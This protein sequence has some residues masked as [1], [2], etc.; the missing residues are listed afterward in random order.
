MI[1]ID[2]LQEAVR[3]GREAETANQ[4][5][6][7]YIER[8]RQSIFQ[9]WAQEGNQELREAAWHLVRGFDLVKKR[10]ADDI[11][12]GTQ[13]AQELAYRDRENTK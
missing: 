8:T 10:I 6:A 13:A 9:A 11:A 5:I 12:T 7:P 2:K 4:A 1:T 3:I